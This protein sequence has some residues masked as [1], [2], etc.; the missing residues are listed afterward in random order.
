[1]DCSSAD[2]EQINQAVRLTDEE[3]YEDALG[4]FEQLLPRLGQGTIEEKRLAASAFSYYGLCVA[5]VRRRY[6]EGVRHCQ[7]SL[8]ANFLEPNHR[9]N[10]A[11]IYLE[12]NERRKA[13]ETLGAGLR[14]DPQ[15]RRLNRILDA[16]GRRKPPVLPFLARS[17]PINV[18]LGRVLRGKRQR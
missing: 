2:R 11:R 4:V 17:N 9:Y 5:M 18:W 1:M 12:R 10:L 16:L 14:I 6:A 15:N 3:Q 8:K 13:V 7:I